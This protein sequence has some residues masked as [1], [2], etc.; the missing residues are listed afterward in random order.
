MQTASA[1]VSYAS[2][3]SGANPLTS[4]VSIN[5]QT[6]E[7]TF[8]A[9]SPQ[10]AAICV[11]VE[12]YRNGVKIGEIIRDLQF[13]IANC[14]NQLPTLGGINGVPGVFSISTCQGAQVCFN[15]PANDGNG[16][17]NLTMTMIGSLP[18]GATFTQSGSGNNVTG[19]F[20]WTPPSNVTGTYV[21][22]IQTTDNACPI[23]GLNSRA[24]TINVI[25]NPNPP[26]NAGAD[27]AVCQGNSTTLTATSAATNISS[28]VWSPAL[29]LS[30]TTGASVT[31]SPIG[32]TTYTVR[33]TYSDGCFSTDDVIVTVN[34]D[35][36]VDVSPGTGTVCPG[37]NFT[38][39]GATNA[40]PATF[41][42]FDPSMTALGT[43]SV[44]GTLSTIT[45]TVPTAAGTY[46]YRLLVTNTSS[47]CTTEAFASL[48]VG[49]PPALPS[50][51]NIYASPSGTPGAAGTQTDPTSL[52]SALS[53]AACQNAV[54]KLAI[55][56]YVIDN[57]LTLSSFVTIEGGFD[58]TNGWRKTSQAGATT[59]HRSALNLE[60]PANARRIVAF[61]GNTVT[62]FR[63]QDLTITTANAPTT[64]AEGVS[65]YGLHLTSCS[66]YDIVRCQ[67]LPGAA[68]AGAGDDNPATYNAT[69]DGANGGNGDTGAQGAAGQ[70][71]CNATGVDQGG[72]GGAGGSGGAGGANATIIGGS[73]TS[74]FAGGTGGRGRNEN[75]GAP[76]FVGTAGSGP[77]PGAGGAGGPADSNGNDTPYGGTGGTGGAGAAG[78]NGITPASGTFG[79]G[80][81][82]PANGTN[83]TAGAGG[84]GGGGGGGAG[85]DTD[86]CDAAGGGGSGGGGGGGG[87]GAGR[88]AFGGG[89]SFAILLFNNGANGRVVDCNATP[90]AAGAGGLGGRG[91]LG[92][93]GG[94]SPV[95]AGCSDGDAN[96]GGFGGV[97]G[98]GGNGGNGGNGATGL[99]IAIRL[100]GT[101][102]PLQT[103][104]ANFNLA[105]QPVIGVSNVNCTNVNVNYTTAASV[106][107]DFDVASNFA[108][109]PT[110]TATNNTNTQYSQIGRYSVQAGAQTYTGFHNISF[111]GAITPVIQTNATQIGTD[112]FQLC[113]GQFAIFSSVYPA[114]TYQWN[115]NGAVAN[116]G[117]V[118]ITPSL[119]FNTPGFYPVTLNFITDCCG[120]STPKTIFLYVDRLPTPTGSG[121]VAICQGNS[122]TLTLNNLVAG[123]SVVWTP[124]TGILNRTANT[125]T[126]QPSA[127]TVYS[128]AVYS[129]N[130][131]GGRNRLSCPV[132]VNFNVTVNPQ[133]L[134]NFTPTAPTC[135]NN[136]QLQANVAG[137]NY[138]FSWSTGANT[139]NATSS[140]LTNLASG[141]YSLTVSHTTT[142]CTATATS[143]LAPA[144]AAPVV[145]LQSSTQATCGLNNGSATVATTGG[146]APYTYAWNIGGGNSP[147]RTGL[148]PGSYTITST[149]AN[150]CRSVITINITTPG[151]VTLNL[152]ST[153]NPACG[154]YA[155]GSASVEA[156][157]GQGVPSYLW[158]NGQTTATATGLMAG[159]ATVT[160]TDAIGCTAVRTVTL[161]A[162]PAIS[163]TTTPSAALC[164]SQTT[165]SIAALVTG[166]AGGYTYLWNPSAQVTSTAINL[167][168]GTYGLTVTDAS[169]CTATAT[170]T[171]AALTNS[172]LPT[173]TGPTGS[174]CPNTTVNLSAT[175]GVAGSG[176]VLR[177]YSGAGGT[178]SL[179]GTGA[180]LSFVPSANTT[181]Y[182]RR[183]GTCNITADASI[184]I[185]LKN[186]IYAANGTTTNT[187][188]TD[189]SGW[190]HFFVGNDIIFSVQG[191]IA[192][193]PAGFPRVTIWDNNAYYQQTQGP[194]TPS[195]CVNGWTPGE[196]RFEMERS[197][198]VDL[199]GAAPSGLYNIRFYYQPAERAAIEVAAINWMLTYP[200][201]GYTYKY[202]Y[203]LGFYWFKDAAATYSAPTYDGTHYAGL[204]G[205]TP[206]SINYAEISNIPSFSGGS[207]A[208][209]LVPNTILSAQWHSFTGQNLGRVN[210]LDWVVSQE[211]ENA[212][213]ELQR[214]VNGL[215]F[216]TIATLPVQPRQAEPNHYQY[217]DLSPMAGLNYYR[218]RLVNPDGSHSL[219]TVVALEV[220]DKG[221]ENYRFYPNPNKGEIFYEFA[222]TVEEQVQVEVLDVLGRK[223][224]VFN[225]Q[226]SVGQQQWAID[227]RGLPS[228]SY[229][230]RATHQGTGIVRTSVSIKE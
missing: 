179:L 219:S 177:W 15:I 104:I 166:G 224:K 172:T 165:G 94:T 142:G 210:R 131:A 78:T 76:G 56:T 29:G 85:R 198:N 109:P 118:R 71:R 50:C 167:S 162:P 158:S 223:V 139:L 216:Q 22:S 54:I 169:G 112:T 222:T 205:S 117:S 111:D 182:V 47:G 48:T 114:D 113:A 228:G 79:L 144:P 187:Y 183:E 201:C 105:A 197:W 69:W 13:V 57:P 3:R 84:S 97:G 213:F 9:T 220:E 83:G 8:T 119:Q 135:G 46:P 175:G 143:F 66:A 7:M 96:R 214:S 34:P 37:G 98:R 163:I 122:T 186:Y 202:P 130:T 27:V 75:D 60:G 92:G 116:P 64:G 52:A 174:I 191:N 155:T 101:S 65:T 156:S 125:V 151:N 170:S 88:G 190:H 63:L 23:P 181:V 10:V 4:P 152:L 108:S 55:G 36:L 41:A 11:R 154:N 6:G 146:L 5:S 164:P 74:G 42:W 99:S 140:T 31:A 20:C 67:I 196:E 26:V 207:G 209:I 107:W 168:A 87:G 106:D 73:A 32:T 93:N 189:N 194:F 90:G 33:M 40:S 173:L 176:S 134:I 49:A 208:V 19:N 39:T 100:E 91:G 153:T 68:S 38:L 226:A 150:N 77:S 141:A 95:G 86:G 2:G 61:Y 171:I 62:G 25:P 102:T 211:E 126:I 35:P 160:V 21:F 188:C 185:Q 193:A 157:G 230:L 203:P 70:C 229:L 221:S 44:S 58:P 123:D 200:A 215:D 138:N 14:S 192:A 132:I 43:G 204:I 80:F 225:L 17:D 212:Y 59:I 110:A 12:E 128:A 124:S 28:I 159:N 148:A 1:T 18:G 72:N 120:L 133:P 51:V 121:P 136:G 24:Y 184:N 103:S 217:H 81:F 178:G 53:R 129:Y 16:G 149:D 218:L 206:N 147:T 137:G 89:S 82:I 127:S 45:V 145:F 161:T 199:G 115:F 195:S 227:L 30:S 180:S